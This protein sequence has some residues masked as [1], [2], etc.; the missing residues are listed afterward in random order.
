MIYIIASAS[1]RER[2]KD[3]VKQNGGTREVS[4]LCGIHNDN[5]HRY[6]RGARSTPMNFID[7][8]CKNIDMDIWEFLHE[9]KLKSKNRYFKVSKEISIEE[10][11]FLG[12]LLTEGHIPKN[13]FRV[14]ISQHN[15]MYLKKLKKNLEE[16][17]DIQNGMTISPDKNNWKLRINISA[18]REYFNLRYKIPMGKKS[19]VIQVP[20]DMFNLSKEKQFAFISGCIDGDGSFSYNWRKTKRYNYKVPRIMFNSNSE[21]F[22]EGLQKIL[23]KYNII[24]RINTD[25]YGRNKLNISKAEDCIK[26]F[27]NLYPYLIHKEKRNH[28]IKILSEYQF[29]NVLR[30]RNS[31]DV[32]LRWKN[33]SGF[34]WKEFADFIE[35]KCHYKASPFTVKNWSINWFN[36]PLSVIIEA[37]NYLGEKCSNWIPEEYLFLL[38]IRN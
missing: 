12:W 7:F 5:I 9:E 10:C 14:E 26:L 17:F 35:K 1:L 28:F 30:V 19:N 4:K 11:S 37:C 6:L 8:I 33:R 21:E 32:I 13:G 16:C 18:M 23:K 31:G 24:S 25:K 3:F 20:E 2:M 27:H 29:L 38:S 15:R 34:T 36:P 22:L